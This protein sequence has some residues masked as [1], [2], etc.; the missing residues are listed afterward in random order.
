MTL[1]ISPS[2]LCTTFFSSLFR[3]SMQIWYASY[4]RFLKQLLLC[5]KSEKFG[6]Q[7]TVEQEGEQ[8]SQKTFPCAFVWVLTQS[9]LNLFLFRWLENLHSLRYFSLFSSNES[10]AGKLLLLLNRWKEKSFKLY[11]PFLCL[12]HL[13]YP[14]SSLRNDD[15][16][17]VKHLQW[18]TS[19]VLK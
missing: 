16:R 2:K 17:R 4:V 6:M 9:S 18:N 3:N 1:R 19:R 15:V 12:F 13:I 14:W 10:L 11:S 8:H 7:C 5:I